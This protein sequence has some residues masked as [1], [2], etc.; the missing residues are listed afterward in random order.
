MRIHSLSVSYSDIGR[1]LDAIGKC[2]FTPPKQL[3]AVPLAYEKVTAAP[4]I[5]N[6][7]KT[8]IAA[9]LDGRAVD[10][11]LEAT[12]IARLVAEERKSLDQRV[13]PELLAEFGKR[14]DN[15]GAD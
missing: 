8:L 3:L 12:A 5:P 14:L 6:P 4:P 9:A 13:E 2:G 10:K 15:G 7:T 11:M 1:F